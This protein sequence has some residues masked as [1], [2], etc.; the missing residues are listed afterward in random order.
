MAPILCSFPMP[1]STHPGPVDSLRPKLVSYCMEGKYLLQCL[2]RAGG[3]RLSTHMHQSPLIEFIVRQLQLAA[4]EL[5]EQI[6]G[7]GN[8]KERD[9]A[10]FFAHG[11]KDRLRRC[12]LQYDGLASH[13]E[14]TGTSASLPPCG[15]GEG[16]G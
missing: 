2:M 15:R 8:E 16:S 14:V 10:P 9:G 11:L 12:P 4:I 3:M 7:P 13:D 5:D 6:L 1:R